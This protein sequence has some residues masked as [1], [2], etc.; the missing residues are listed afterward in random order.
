VGQICQLSENWHVL[1]HHL[2][3]PPIF[4]AVLSK[5]EVKVESSI[6]DLTNMYHY[7]ETISHRSEDTTMNHV[8]LSTN[9]QYFSL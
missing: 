7:N 3:A 2:C 6:F 5:A 1:A 4:M 8:K 9:K